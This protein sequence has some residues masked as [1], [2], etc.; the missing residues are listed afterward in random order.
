MGT[1]AQPSEVSI[2]RKPKG[3]GTELQVMKE[4][5]L[6]EKMYG[7]SSELVPEI[8]SSTLTAFVKHRVVTGDSP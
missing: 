1:I 2:S 4:S 5:T 6:E 8:T 3:Y 7:T